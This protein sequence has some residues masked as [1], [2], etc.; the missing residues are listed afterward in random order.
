[1]NVTQ[2]IKLADWHSNDDNIDV[3]WP[4]IQQLLGVDH[5]EWLLKQPRE[6]CQLVVDKTCEQFALVAEFYDERHL[7]QY[8]LMWAK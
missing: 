3:D 1:M 5:V 7:V 4:K 6:K 2:R 8:H